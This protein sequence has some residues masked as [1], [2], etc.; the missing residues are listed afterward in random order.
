LPHDVTNANTRVIINIA[1]A[2]IPLGTIVKLYLNSE[3]GADQIISGAAIAISS[4]TCAATFPLG[5]TATLA[6]A[7]W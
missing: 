4:A 6:R 5:I 7:V 2:N 3:T 1:G